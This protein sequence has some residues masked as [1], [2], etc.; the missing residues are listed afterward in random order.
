[1]EHADDVSSDGSPIAMLDAQDEVLFDSRHFQDEALDAGEDFASD[2]EAEDWQSSTHSS[3][4]TTKET[5][6]E[7]NTQSSVKYMAEGFEGD[8]DLPLDPPPGVTID[9]W[10][11][12][13]RLRLMSKAHVHDGEKNGCMDNLLTATCVSL[14]WGSLFIVMLNLGCLAFTG[15]HLPGLEAGYRWTQD[16]VARTWSFTRQPL[17]THMMAVFDPEYAASLPTD[18]GLYE[19]YMHGSPKQRR[20]IVETFTEGSA[21]ARDVAM[22]SQQRREDAMQQHRWSLDGST[23][24]SAVAASGDGLS[25]PPD[26]DS[27]DARVKRYN[28]MVRKRRKKVSMWPPPHTE[29]PGRH[30]FADAEATN[31]GNKHPP[32]TQP[33]QG[34]GMRAAQVTAD[35]LIEHSNAQDAAQAF[36]ARR[37]ALINAG[38]PSDVAEAVAVKEMKLAA[39]AAQ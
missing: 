9:E 36:I 22:L 24:V 10:A 15:S 7:E 20:K 23:V 26:Y 35:G 14:V 12:L 19:T 4:P 32:P 29:Q 34:G 38:L 3:G 16:A 30:P 37:Q 18:Q 8:D 6:Q 13:R 33:E 21:D 5:Q 2:S 28:D 25:R 17:H 11:R 31:A 1:M 39:Q 27:I